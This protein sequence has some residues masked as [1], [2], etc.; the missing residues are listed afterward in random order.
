GGAAT[1]HRGGAAGIRSRRRSRHDRRASFAGSGAGAAGLG[2][3]RL[4][5]AGRMGWLRTRGARDLRPADHRSGGDPIARQ[6]GVGP[7]R[8]ASC[9]N[10][11]RRGL[12][13]L[14]PSPSNLAGAD[15][16]V[17]GMPKA[18]AAAVTSLAGA[19]SVDPM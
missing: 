4:A 2:A 16:A 19:I 15:L 18:R 14:F 8:A 6:A 7:R 10:E 5:R 11:R 12:T 3:A 17:L 13:Y 9:G 1:D